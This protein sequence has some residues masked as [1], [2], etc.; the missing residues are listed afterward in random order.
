MGVDSTGNIVGG[1]ENVIA[2]ESNNNI[3]VGVADLQ[4]PS[5]LSEVAQRIGVELPQPVE[6]FL[7]ESLPL[8]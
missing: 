7:D 2:D 1:I 4:D 8:P 5:L 3:V 6:P